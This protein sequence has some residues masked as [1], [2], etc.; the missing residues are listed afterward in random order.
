MSWNHS[1]AVSRRAL[2]TVVTHLTDVLQSARGRRGARHT[3]TGLHATVGT[4]LQVAC[5]GSRTGQRADDVAVILTANGLRLCG[6]HDKN[7]ERIRRFVGA[8]RDFLE[9]FLRER[10]RHAIGIGSRGGG[11]TEGDPR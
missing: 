2:A 3:L 7:A 8:T 10:A 9:W 4:L 1:N 5:T 11:Q 6:L